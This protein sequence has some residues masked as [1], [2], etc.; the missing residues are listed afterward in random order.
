M[1]PGASEGQKAAAMA[2]LGHIGR[3]GVAEG[4]IAGSLHAALVQMGIL[5]TTP[6]ATDQGETRKYWSR[7]CSRAGTDATAAST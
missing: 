6:G 5:M 7:R 2:Q 1:M 3:L 4:E